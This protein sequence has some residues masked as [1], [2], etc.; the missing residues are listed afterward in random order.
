VKRHGGKYCS[1]SCQ[2]RSRGRP[3]AERFLDF[4][5]PGEPDACW[6]W[7]GTRDHD[8]YGVIGDDAR[9]QMRAHRLAWERVNGPLPPGRYVLHHC[10]NPPC[11]NP[12]HLFVGTIADNNHDMI[13][14]GRDNPA[15]GKAHWNFKHGRYCR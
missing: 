13:R 3:L 5:R 11:C 2:N 15:H 9:R 14:K 6:P 12:A 7:L 10:D 4:Y 1:R 8:G